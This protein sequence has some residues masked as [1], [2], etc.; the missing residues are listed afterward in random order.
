MYHSILH[1]SEM[2]EDIILHIQKAWSYNY[3]RLLNSIIGRN[4]PDFANLV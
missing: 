1:I 2:T 3:H 4:L